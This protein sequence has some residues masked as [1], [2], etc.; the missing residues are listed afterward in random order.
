MY[1]GSIFSYQELS[2]INFPVNKIFCSEYKE[3][4]ETGCITVSYCLLY[5]IVYCIVLFTVSYCLLY[6]TVYLL[7]GPIKCKITVNKI[8]CSK[9]LLYFFLSVFQGDSDRELL[10]LH[11]E[12]QP[13]G[14][15]P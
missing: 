3:L 10:V 14:A 4:S 7:T 12:L 15:S 13:G 1:L 11:P 9:F 5:R 2:E 8:F 6:R